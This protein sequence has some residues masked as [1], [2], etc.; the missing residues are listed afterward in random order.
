MSSSPK[1]LLFA[2]FM[3]LMQNSPYL[4]GDQPREVYIAG[5]LKTS[6]VEIV[7]LLPA[8]S[9]EN[10]AH[11]KTILLIERSFNTAMGV[12]GNKLEVSL[13]QAK[14]KQGTV[15]LASDAVSY[16][17]EFYLLIPAPLEDLVALDRREG[18]MTW[19]KKPLYEPYSLPSDNPP[20]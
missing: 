17:K 10:S 1:L 16:Q 14:I 3:A 18:F 6:E 7:T 4:L 13:R 9:F 8:R 11:P 2:D 19:L 20:G 12:H 5:I 15:V